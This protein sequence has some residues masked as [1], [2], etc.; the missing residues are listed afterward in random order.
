MGWLYFF[1]KNPVFYPEDLQKHKLSST[2]LPP[3]MRQA[4]E[5][6]GYDIVKTDFKDLKMAMQKGNVNAI[7]IS[8]IVAAHG[9]FFTLAPNMCTVKVSPVVGGLVLSKKTWEK[10]PGEY[11]KQMMEVVQKQ[12]DEFCEKIEKF[13]NEA[14]VEMEEYDLIVN[15]L[16]ADALKKWQNTSDKF[17]DKLKRKVFSEEVI[18][19][20]RKHLKEYR[21]KNSQRPK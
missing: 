14:I 9:Q 20:V 21:E 10:I 18:E 6:A 15:K 13:E 12:Y 7:S 5:N 19:L 8:P 17:V 1:S 16:P 3:E 2:E 4:W 11:K